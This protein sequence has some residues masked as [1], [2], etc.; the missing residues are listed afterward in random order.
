MARRKGFDL[1]SGAGRV[2]ALRP[3]LRLAK[4]ASGLRFSSHFSNA[5]EIPARLSL[6]PAAA[7]RNPRRFYI[8]TSN[9]RKPY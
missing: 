5:A 6:P 4:N 1:R 7:G 9:L 8:C 3:A 2:A